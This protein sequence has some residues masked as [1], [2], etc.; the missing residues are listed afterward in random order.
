[1]EQILMKLWSLI[2]K[3]F[4]V[5]LACRRRFSFLVQNHYNANGDGILKYVANKNIEAMV[6]S[7]N[8]SQLPKD[9]VL[10]YP[11]ITNVIANEKIT[12]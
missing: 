8:V 7:A 6:N 5:S 2:P 11:E 12:D 3:Y 10:K 1:M 4:I 9:L